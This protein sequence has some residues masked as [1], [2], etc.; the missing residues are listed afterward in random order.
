MMRLF[1]GIFIFSLFASSSTIAQGKP[2]YVKFNGIQSQGEVP[3]DFLISS[4]DKVNHIAQQV[5]ASQPDIRKYQAKKFAEQV[6]FETEQILNSGRLTF[7]DPICQYVKSVGDKLTQ[8]DTLFKYVR[9]YLIQSNISNAFSTHDGIIFITEGMLARLNNEAQLAAILSHELAHFAKKHALISFLDKS[10]NKQMSMDNDTRIKEMNQFSQKKELEAD[11][12]GLLMYYKAGYPKEEVTPT[13]QVL[14]YSTSPF[15]NEVIPLNYWDTPDLQMPREMFVKSCPPLLS[16]SSFNNMA[17]LKSHPGFIERI[18]HIQQILN[19]LQDWGKALDTFSNYSFKAIQKMARYETIRNDLFNRHYKTALYS[20][21]LLE[22]GN[23]DPIFLAKCKVQAWAGIGNLAVQQLHGYEANSA[24]I[25]GE[26]YQLFQWMERM[27]NAQICA[28]AL[29]TIHECYLKYP[30]D[31]EIK[32]IYHYFLHELISHSDFFQNSTSKKSIADTAIN[33]QN[34]HYFLLKTVLT[35]STFMHAFQTEKEKLTQQ[36][37]LPTYGVD[38]FLAIEPMAVQLLRGEIDYLASKKIQQSIVQSISNCSSNLHL[39]QFPINS[40]ILDSIKT[41]GYNDKNILLRAIFQLTLSD[42]TGVFPVEY[43]AIQ[44]ISQRYHCSNLLFVFLKNTHK[45]LNLKAIALGMLLPPIGITALATGISRLNT[46]VLSVL[47]VN[48]NNFQ[49]SSEQT[50]K[51]TS[52]P[53]LR[54]VNKKLCL[55]L[56]KVSEK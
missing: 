30:K 18:L 35:D 21:F 15:A 14:S 44:N 31:E 4:E 38:T 34:F 54:R 12:L 40:L 20:I 25:D 9:Y 51:F 52:K 49:I 22:G 28:F 8:K 6:C 13:F 36:T 56:K 46:A 50:S 45:P 43:S 2:S 27:S 39:T 10:K 32:A 33:E 1:L 17:S 26:S 3:S 48:L 41:D 19:Q 29:F 11:S 55:I 47:M 42:S 5:L 24:S 16:K 7:G 37:D 53:S 23:S